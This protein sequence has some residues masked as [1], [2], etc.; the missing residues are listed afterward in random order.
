MNRTSIEWCDFSWNPVT[1][2]KRGCSYCY[3]A[4]MAHRFGKSFDPELH[5][6]R[7]YDPRKRG[8]A[9]KIFVCSTADLF[10]PW[11]PDIWVW[12]VLDEARSTYCRHHT[13]IFLTKSPGRYAEFNPWPENAWLGATVTNQADADE[14]IPELLL[15]DARIRFISAE[16]ILGS[17]DIDN[18]LPY[19]WW[20]DPD[21]NTG[22]TGIDWVI[23]GAQTGPGS[24]EP[25]MDWVVNLRMQ[26]HHAGIPVFLK[27]NLGILHPPQEFPNV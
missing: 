22:E 10:G 19:Y 25:E 2:C 26:A 9:A 11:V 1:G 14:R 8:K 23:I 21:G 7:L 27:N 13:F 18:Y 16:P 20:K 15:A 24:V 17:I 5:P 12:Q 4:R 3:A 6:E